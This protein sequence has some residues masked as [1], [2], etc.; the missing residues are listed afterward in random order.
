MTHWLMMGFNESV[1]YNAEDVAYSASF[2]TKKERSEANIVEVKQRIKDYGLKGVVD[3]FNRKTIYN[4]ND[5]T[6]SWSG[7][8]HFFMSENSKNNILASFLKRL[9]YP[10]CQSKLRLIYN[11][12]L[13]SVWY[14]LFCLILVSFIIKKN[15]KTYVLIVSLLGLILF[16]TLFEARA[17]Y[18]Y[19]YAPLFILIASLGAQKIEMIFKTFLI[20]ISN[21]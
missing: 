3:L 14:G 6:F 11:L 1:G 10:Q 13:Q 18:I 8:G 4:F 12:I 21:Y 2:L 17:R 20:K 19:I 5:A 7:E 9:Y 15:K 16:E